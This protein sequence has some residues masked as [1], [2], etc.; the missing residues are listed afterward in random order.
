MRLFALV[1]LV[2]V[3][4]AAYGVYALSRS[5]CFVLG[6]GS[7]CRVDTAA[8]LVALTFDD[9]PT[10]LGLDA[11]LPV[12]RRYNAKATFFLV[13]RAVEADP[14]L[15]RRLIAAGHE[16]GNHS[17]SHK[18]MVFR[19]AAFY[20]G[21]IERTQALLADSGSSPRLFRP[22]NGKKLLGLPL[23]VRRHGLKMVLWDIEDPTT[24]DPHAFAEA[25]VAQAR[26]GSIILIHPMYPANETGRQALPAI[27]EGLQ[28]KGLKVASVSELLAAERVR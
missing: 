5:R 19:S 12:L 23:A 28:A 10:E 26:P 3:V 24:A 25:V 15:A 2:L 13:G 22:P 27:L 9:G 7:V 8:P 20:D 11:V 18:R 21:E 6:G 16:I 4:I 1:A 17:Y 14:A